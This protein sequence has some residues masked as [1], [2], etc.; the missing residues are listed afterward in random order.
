M[1]IS[2]N[3]L[4]KYL[5]IDLP[6]VE[7]EK[8]LTAIGLEVEGINTVKSGPDLT[9]VVVGH[10]LTK[11]Q[12]PNADKLSITTV[13]IG[14]DTPLNIVC[15]APNVAADQ[16]VLVATIGTKLPTEEG[17][18]PFVIKK[19]KIRGE[20]SE[21]MICAD[22]ELGLGTDHSGIK[23]LD[24][25]A[26]IGQSAEDY[27]AF[28][29]DI[30]FEIGLT[31]NRSDATCH[32]GVAEDIKAYLDYHNNT[33]TTIEYPDLSA[34][35]EGTDT[36]F[37]IEIHDEIACPRYAG[38]LLEHIRV[39]PSPK[40]LVNHLENI[41]VRS[42]N[43]VVDITN[44][45]L[46][47]MG[48]PLH[49]FDAQKIEGQKIKVQTLPKGTPF[50][51]LDESTYEL[52]ENDL[53]ICDG[54]NNGLCIA[55]VFGGIHSGVTAETTSIFLE[56]AH[57]EAISLRKT[58][59][60]HLLRTDAAMVFEKGSDPNVVVKA[61]KR[62]VL[63]LQE[64]A[65]ATVA[66]KLIDHYPTTI[67]PKQIELS[68]GKVQQLMGVDLDKTEIKKILSSL[69][70]S[71]VDKTEDLLIVH[72]PTNK[73]DVLRDV[74]VIEEILRIYGFDHVALP[75]YIRTAI[76]QSEPLSLFTLRNR[77]AEILTG[78]G[79]SEMMGMSL[80]DQKYVDEKHE[81]LVRINNTS[82]INYNIMRPHLMYSALEAVMYNLNRQQS[83]LKFFENGRS[84]KKEGDGFIE[85]NQLSITIVGDLFE[86]DWN[87]PQTRPLGFFDLKAYVELVLTKLGIQS[88]QTS[89]C[90]DPLYN[91]GLT[92][93]RGPQKM[94]I[95]GLVN[96]DLRQ[97]YGVKKEVWTATFNW[98]ILLPF[99]QKQQVSVQEISKFPSV[100]RDLAL[101]VDDHVKM[102]DI[103]RIAFKVD[104]KWLKKIALFDVYKNDE[105]LGSGKKS[106]AINYL[107]ENTE[108]TLVDKEV[109]KIMDKLIGQYEH[110]LGAI[111][112]R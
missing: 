55:G 82:N 45:V 51:A 90:D 58:S 3:W 78:M 42:I 66:S 27:L 84:Y 11:E 80:I 65:E 9:G 69:Q 95:F 6:T 75:G 38:I 85:S 92:Y 35:Q 97:T 19:G 7:I 21:G 15:G 14:T 111:I 103:E 59:F 71:V 74:D 62:A 102:A 86:S 46:H 13:D 28:E 106:Y 54:A 1:N 16:K 100:K 17:A 4:K 20:V 44:F 18:K 107:F 22:D 25:N 26:I 2:L 23:V 12:H 91:Y 109:N 89:E 29:T 63:L 52:G 99:V 64:Y 76:P 105:Q 83:N 94:V 88:F 34:F 43:N 50:N 101:V 48:Q 73:A 108:K 68:V 53:M 57:F 5:A 39:K 60:S 72:V 98:D 87:N 36:S 30:I 77:M 96:K 70:M 110:Q 49:A 8:I 61:L 31:P 24:T 47:E 67:E 41:G 10:V 104:K 32:I 81:Q 93:H 37:S 112:R 40:W 79:F 33:T 56:S